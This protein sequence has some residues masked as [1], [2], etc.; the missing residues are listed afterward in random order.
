[1]AADTYV[2]TANG[3]VTKNGNAEVGVVDVNAQIRI[4]PAIT[5]EDGT[6]VST[7]A[8]NVSLEYSVRSV[9]DEAAILSQDG[10]TGVLGTEISAGTIGVHVPL[11][12]R[13]SKPGD[14]I[15]LPVQTAVTSADKTTIQ[16]PTGQ[17]FVVQ[18]DGALVNPAVA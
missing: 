18:D 17:H 13:R 3:G 12:M 2:V 11:A 10:G 9:A 5:L 7:A 16:D 1:M 8:H 15:T 14:I 6:V 4:R